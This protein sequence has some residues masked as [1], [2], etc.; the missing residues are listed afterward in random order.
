MKKK[1]LG[2]RQVVLNY[3]RTLNPKFSFEMLLIS[4]AQPHRA[5]GNVDCYP[6]MDKIK[7]KVYEV[8]TREECRNVFFD[9]F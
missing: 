8:C 5:S 3:L 7:K 9:F 4:L 1:K 6:K 2:T